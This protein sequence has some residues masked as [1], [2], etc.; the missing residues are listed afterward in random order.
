MFSRRTRYPN[1][2]PGGST[3]LRMCALILVTIIT[4]AG[5]VHAETSEWMGVFRD[6]DGVKIRVDL[7]IG[8]DDSYSLA[9]GVP[10]SCRME[11]EKLIEHE[12]EIELKVEDTSGGFCDDRFE[13]D[14]TISKNSATAWVAV[15]EK[16][17]I[18]FKETYQLL[19]E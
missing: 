1:L 16:R 5:I 14:L 7:S 4:M 8:E 13:A 11:L 17:S 3:F 9:Y 18:D 15:I 2:L 6:S 19:K 10:R 12:D